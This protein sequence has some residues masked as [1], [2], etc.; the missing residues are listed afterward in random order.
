MSKIERAWAAG[1]FDGEG[2]TYYHGPELEYVYG[3]GSGRISMKVSQVERGVLDRFQ[4]AVGVGKVLGPYPSRRGFQDVYR[5]EI[6]NYEGVKKAAAAL[7]PYLSD[8]KREQMTSAMD[9]KEAA[10]EMKKARGGPD[11]NRTTGRYEPKVF[12]NNGR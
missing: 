6:S 11:R 10:L 5:W 1:F 8:V 4:A 9:R 3:G 2:G 7:W 12:V